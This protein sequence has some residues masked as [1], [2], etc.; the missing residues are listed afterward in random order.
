[1]HLRIPFMLVACTALVLP[2]TDSSEVTFKNHIMFRNL[3]EISTSKSH[4]KVALLIDLHAFPA[5]LSDLELECEKLYLLA[6]KTVQHLQTDTVPNSLPLIR[7]LQEIQSHSLSS[8]SEK[9][10]IANDYQSFF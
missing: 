10:N 6:D 2:R 1:M 5:F 3:R 8:K 9:N 4:W 7:T